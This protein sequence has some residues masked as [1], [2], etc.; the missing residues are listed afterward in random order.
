MESRRGLACPDPRHCR[1]PSCAGS[2]PGQVR[3]LSLLPVRSGSPDASQVLLAIQ[4]GSREWTWEAIH[5]EVAREAPEL[6]DWF[7]LGSL[8]RWRTGDLSLRPILKEFR[9]RATGVLRHV[10]EEIVRGSA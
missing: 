6:G 1:V 8:S 2:Q 10:Y 9:P 3:V 7:D 5:E 4:E